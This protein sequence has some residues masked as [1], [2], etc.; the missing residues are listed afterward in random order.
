MGGVLERS[1]KSSRK[2]KNREELVVVFVLG[3]F[4]VSLTLSQIM[5]KP[6]IKNTNPKQGEIPI[7]HGRQAPFQK[8]PF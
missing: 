8:R 2:I 7:Y 5:R 4:G 3:V 1:R 6:Y